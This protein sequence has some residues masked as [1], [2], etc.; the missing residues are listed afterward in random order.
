MCNETPDRASESRMYGEFFSPTFLETLRLLTKTGSAVVG[1]RYEQSRLYVRT[2]DPS[3]ERPDSV[4][5][6]TPGEPA[7]FAQV[8]VFRFPC[9]YSEVN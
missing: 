9:Q 7:G 4:W 1:V 2:E 3:G 5:C 6:S 8:S